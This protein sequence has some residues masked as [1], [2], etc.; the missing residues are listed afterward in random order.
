MIADEY[1]HVHRTD[2]CALLS[3][4]QCHLM[5]LRLNLLYRPDP[6]N[7]DATKGLSLALKQIDLTI[8]SKNI[9][10][11]FRLIGF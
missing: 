1:M 6:A 4:W 3:S 2:V 10:L 11:T 8:V 5:E 9:S 7:Y